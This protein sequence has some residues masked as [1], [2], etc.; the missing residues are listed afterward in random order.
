MRQISQNTR[1]VENF[2]H[3]MHMLASASQTK[4]LIN[5]FHRG[6]RL[7]YEK[8]EYIIRPGEQP[9]AVFYIESGLIKAF[10]I[11][12]YGEENL[13][14]I[15]R[16]H[17]IFPLIWAITGQERDVIYQAMSSVQVWRLSREEYLDFLHNHPDAL[18]PVLDMTLEMYRIHSERIMSLEYRTVRERLISFLLSSAQRFGKKEGK[19]ILIDVPLRQQDIASSI[20][21]S[22]ETTGRELSALE[23]KGYIETKRSMIVLKDRA[24][25]KKYL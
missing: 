18:A 1:Y 8:G 14:I 6:T 3:N 10:D 23:Q 16:E 22:R 7:R 13:L 17:E 20:N 21:A 4:E 19:A 15:R 12:K 11:T 2:C 9:S 24:A 5:T 25:L